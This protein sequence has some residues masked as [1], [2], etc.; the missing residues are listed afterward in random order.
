M[1]VEARFADDSTED[2]TSYCSFESLDSATATIDSSGQVMPRAV[3]DAG[4]IVRYRA[5]PAVVR[6]IIPRAGT[7]PFPEVKANNFVDTQILKKLRDLNLPPA[8]LSD[9]A[10]FLRRICLD[11]TGELPAAG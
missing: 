1:K 10:T 3:G 2:V 7:A 8:G 11:V 6:I 9:D 4:L 5:Q